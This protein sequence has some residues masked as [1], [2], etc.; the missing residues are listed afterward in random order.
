MKLTGSWSGEYTYGSDYG[1][2]SGVSVPFKVSVSESWFGR[3]AGYVRDEASRGGMPERGRVRGRRRGA[4]IEFIKSMPIHYAWG[5]DSLHNLSAYLVEVGG[6][7]S[8]EDLPPHM[9]RYVGHIAADGQSI[10]GAWSIVPWSVEIGGQRLQLGSG[11]GTWTAKKDSHS[12]SA[13]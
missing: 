11:D 7:E 4:R 2:G 13:V 12:V 8:P 9:I 1:D 5:G 3:F 10:E 6:F